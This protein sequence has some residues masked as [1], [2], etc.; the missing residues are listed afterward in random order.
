M[1]SQLQ[2]GNKPKV[3]KKLELMKFY[4]IYLTYIAIC[5]Y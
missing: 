2:G 3:T 1:G 5:T 4:N